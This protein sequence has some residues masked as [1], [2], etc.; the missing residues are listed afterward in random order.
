MNTVTF[1]PPPPPV[2][3]GEV[4]ENADIN[5]TVLYLNATDPDSASISYE[6]RGLAEGRFTV[7]SS[8]RISVS[9][10]IDREEFTGGEVVFLAFA[11]GGA[12]ATVDVVVQ[13]ADINDYAPR[14]ADDFSGRVEENTHPGED[15]LFVTEVR[16]VD[17]DNMENGTVTYAL[18]SGIESG[19][20]IDSITGRITAHAVFDREAKPTYTLIVQATD[21]GSALQLSST[22]QVLVIIG[23]DN[24]NKPFFPF[25]YMYARIFENTPIGQSVVTIPSIDL[26][27]GT[28]ASITYTL[29]SSSSNEVKFVLDSVSGVISVAGSLDYEIPLHRT[30]T[31]TIS[32]NDPLYHSEANGT[33]TVDVL[34]Q[35]DNS[36]MIE[37]P[38]YLIQRS[39]NIA[40]TFPAGNVLARLQASDPDSGTNSE[41]TF[42]ISEGDVNGDFE[43]SVDG[44]VLGNIRNKKQFDRETVPFYNLV[45][46]VADKGNPP[47]SSVVNVDFNINDV[48]DES[49]KFSQTNYAVSILENTVPN[50]FLLQVQATDPDTGEGG[51]ISMYAITDGNE[52]GQFGIN[53]I[54]GNMSS[55]V[56]FD[57]EERPFYTL[58]VI[59]VDG[60]VNPNTGTA[61]IEVSILDVND[62]PTLRGGELSV[63]IFAL[64]GQVQSQAIGPINF[65]DADINDSFTECIFTFQNNLNMFFSVARDSC[66]LHLSQPN[67][68]LGLYRYEVLGTDGVFASNNANLTITV[69][70]VA[71]SQIPI[72]HTATLTMNATV[73]DYFRK[74]LN[75]AFHSL[76]AQALGIQSSLLRIFSV[77]PGYFDQTNTVDLFFTAQDGSGGF[78]TKALII[79]RLALQLESLSIL[80]HS[81]TSLPLDPCRSEPCFNQAAC[82]PIL[83]LNETQ[84]T[85]ASREHILLSP[86]IEV[87]YTCDCVPGTSGDHCGINF[88]DCYSNPCLFGAQC[89]DEVNGFGCKCP[90]GT[91]GDDC[92]FNPDECT[93][94]PCLNGATC[95]NGF[96]RYECECLPGY[97]G[98]ECQYHSFRPSSVCASAPCQN[99]G[100]CS[101]GRDGFTCLCLQGFTGEFC[102]ETTTAQG[103]CI[104]NP[105]YNGSTCTDTPQGAVC[106]CSVG[107]TGPKCRWPLNNCELNPCENGGTC[108]PGLY[109]SF[110]C[111]CVPG[112]T[113]ANCSSLVPPCSS[114]PCQNDGRCSNNA[115]DSGYTCECPGLFTGVDC[116]IAVFPEDLCDSIVPSLSPCAENAICTSGRGNF[117]C[118][119]DSEYTGPDCSLDFNISSS[120]PD[121]LPCYSNPCMHGGE[122]SPSTDG[123]SHACS[124]TGGFT[125]ANCEIN[126]DDCASVSCQHGAACVDGIEGFACDCP[127][128]TTGENCQIMCPLGRGGDFCEVAIP[129][130]TDDF[131]TNGTCQEASNGGSP[132]CI[133]NP[134]F[135]GEHC[136]LLNNCDTVSCLNGGTCIATGGGQPISEPVCE[137]LPG[138]SG[139]NCEQLSI[140]FG[141]SSTLPSYRAFNSLDIRGEGKISFEFITVE[142]D[143]LLLYNTQY[144][145]GA[146]TDFIS[147]EIVGGYLQVGVSHG[148]GGGGGG[149]VVTTAR[150]VSSSVR[151]SDGKWHQIA[152]ET[153]GKVSACVYVYVCASVSAM[154]L[155]RI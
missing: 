6:L 130:C 103:G 83:T 19:F 43:I 29:V 139:P 54:S 39:N 80:G 147:V 72:E 66:I 95:V 126:I 134:G 15:G 152:I 96:G 3:R 125:G 150:V 12:L 81:V 135:T 26:D 155:S 60:G 22:T 27:N 79:S 148:G 98:C 105:C 62:N 55:L 88:D 129:L 138:F 140:N 78:L 8:G 59:A 104:S 68:S 46:I 144:Q 114:L 82:N 119:C 64:D 34:D 33:L 70:S 38:E 142:R 67:P 132:I 9:G 52:Q 51:E 42:T 40:E 106:T 115:D 93:M 36:P 94:N 28:N 61:T 69:E 31:L 151:V 86:R 47:R 1:P 5:T 53:P 41:L 90:E 107:F 10:P 145:D 122:C 45:V 74:K 24:D 37:G 85:A 48:N 99:G 118:T 58:T 73:G 20:R 149:G 154:M 63:Q 7:D 75:V 21:R 87:S 18:L 14:F 120:P 77:Q 13:I 113:G 57:R 4:V 136:E 50:P 25:P 23:D 49:P 32:L 141:G 56:R 2:Y 100:E 11:E 109:G 143:G 89:E 131:C 108:D 124:C 127:S 153:Y 110:Q 76:L 112:Y 117:T 102:Q 65:N 16:A 101:A 91:S 17:L 116:E 35:N 92:S 30:F 133:C 71:R 146:S 137:C 123:L 44:G 97:Y 128:Q 111:I 84:I 121:L